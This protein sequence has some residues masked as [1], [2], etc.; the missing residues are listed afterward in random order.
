[1]IGDDGA[2]YPCTGGEGG[3]NVVTQIRT[4]EKDGY[5]AVQLG[6]GTKKEK[7]TS[8]AMS[9]HYETSRT[10]PTRFIREIEM[11]EKELTAGDTVSIFPPV[12][13]G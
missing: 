2:H 5:T 3:P 13:G 10:T 12:A 8:K 11:S 1:M 7:R 4:E 6:I 9:G